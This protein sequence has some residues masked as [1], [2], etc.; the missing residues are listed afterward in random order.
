MRIGIFGGT[1]D[2]IHLGHLVLAE[3]CREQ[4][5][6]EEVWFVPAGE[7]PHKMAAPRSSGRHRREMVEFAIA[8]HAHFK[9]SDIELERDGPSYTVETLSQLHQLHPNEEWWLLIGADSLDNFATWREPERI[10]QLSRIAAVNRGDRSLP[11]TVAFTA[12]FGDRLDV[13]TMP[14]IDLSASDIR[15][16]IAAGRSIRYLV[17]RAVEVYIQE[18]RLY[19]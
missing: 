10:T 1:F 3:Q 4:L 7:P 19:R 11:D 14:G 15:Q 13:V 16:R 17:P 8:G 18:Q 5:G 6:L 2:P 12:L 9:V